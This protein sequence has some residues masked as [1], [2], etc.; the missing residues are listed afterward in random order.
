MANAN[1]IESFLLSFDVFCFDVLLTR[2][3]D[4]KGFFGDGFIEGD[5]SVHRFWLILKVEPK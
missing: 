3:C 4:K 5:N 1:I 2:Q